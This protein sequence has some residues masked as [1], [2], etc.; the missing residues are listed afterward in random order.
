MVLTA[1]D[2]SEIAHIVASTIAQIPNF[3]AAAAPPTVTRVKNL[4]ER[5]FRKIHQFGGSNWRDFSFQFKAATRS[6]SED[7]YR[8]ICWAE[9]E[10]VAADPKNYENMKDEDATKISGDMF[11][12]ITASLTGEPLM[13]MYNCEFNGLE[14]WRRLSK[15]YSPTT[16]LRAMQLMMQI[17]SP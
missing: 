5:H 14:A 16:P 2:I 4:D 11:N 3:A 10:V 6:S 8:I 17:I 15:R 7:A 1:D 12:I 9:M 13:M